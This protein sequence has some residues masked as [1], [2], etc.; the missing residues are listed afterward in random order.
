ML[1]DAVFGKNEGSLFVNGE[2]VG[3]IKVTG[4]NEG[5]PYTSNV[6]KNKKNPTILTGDKENK[7]EL[8]ENAQE[9]FK[10]Q[11]E[12]VDNIIEGNHADN[13]KYFEK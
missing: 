12:F 4:S 11:K 8:I 10:K 3:E 5:K 13:L 7:N 2:Y 6:W 9:E 1:E